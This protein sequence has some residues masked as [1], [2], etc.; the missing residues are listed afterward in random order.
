MLYFSTDVVA[1]INHLLAYLLNSGRNT[2][3][4][5]FWTFA[6]YVVRNL[7]SHTVVG[8]AITRPLQH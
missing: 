6:F 8:H 3:C 4:Y 1:L 5:G 7:A 2:T